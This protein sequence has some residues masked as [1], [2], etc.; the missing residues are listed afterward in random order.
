MEHQSSELSVYERNSLEKK[1][2]LYEF[3]Y[4]VT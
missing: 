4:I 3:L 1:A 2:K